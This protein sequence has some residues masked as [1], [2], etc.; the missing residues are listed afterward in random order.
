MDVNGGTNYSH[1]GTNQ[2]MSVPYTLYAENANIDYD[3]ISTLL[4]NDS[5]FITT[6]SG[7]I[8]GGCDFKY[9]EELMVKHCFGILILLVLIRFPM[10]KIYY[11][12]SYMGSGSGFDLIIDSIK[13]FQ[14]QETT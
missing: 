10:E 1:M 3:S 6:V 11:I 14:D 4:S 13:S 8:G 12:N 7:G 9:P 5:T 2:M